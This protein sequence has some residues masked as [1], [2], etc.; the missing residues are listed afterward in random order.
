MN[1]Y[2]FIMEWFLFEDHIAQSES[3]FTNKNRKENFSFR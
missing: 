3:I 1:I 2:V